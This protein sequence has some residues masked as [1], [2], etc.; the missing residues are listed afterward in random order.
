MG[1]DCLE[2]MEDYYQPI[3][4]DQSLTTADARGD[5]AVLEMANVQVISEMVNLISLP[6]HMNQPEGGQTIDGTLDV[7]QQTRLVN[8]NNEFGWDSR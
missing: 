6:E 1:C 3:E 4:G 2:N 8:C 7:T 5:Q